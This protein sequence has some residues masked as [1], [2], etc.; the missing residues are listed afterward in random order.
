MKHQSV[1]QSEVIRCLDLVKRKI[2][3]DATLGLG[4]HSRAILSS[5]GFVGSIVGL[6]HDTSHLNFARE[7][8]REFSDRFHGYYL[9]FRHLA[10]FV[11]REK[12]NFDGILFDL[13][14]ASPHLDEGERGFS[15]Q[16][17]GPL[18][19]RMD[20]TKGKTAAELVNS[21]SSA[22]LVH[23]FK[24]Y[25]EEP[26]ATAIA[27]AILL[28]RS[29]QP[30][31]TTAQLSQLVEGVYRKTGFHGSRK[32]PATRAFQALRIA[33]N[34]ELSALDLALQSAI[35][36]IAPGGRIVVISYHSLEDRLVKLAFRKAAFPCVC[37][38]KIPVCA[39]GKL[40]ALRILTPRPI[41]PGEDEIR[42][43]P[44]ARSAKLRVAEKLS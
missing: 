43:N 34:E 38:P 6:D 44:R 14:V 11:Q 3:I 33:V 23:I 1:M 10:D 35:S 2:I 13:G 40:P 16:Q 12:I 21:L 42:L 32:H 17:D 26:R 9:N 18:D 25:G 37:P 20:R 22:E 36:L 31:A 15:Y 30:I 7:N 19:M 39:C 29:R 4:G 41:L 8:L 24:N 27:E 28:S 5:P